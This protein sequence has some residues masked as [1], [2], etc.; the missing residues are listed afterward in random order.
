LGSFGLLAFAIIIWQFSP[1]LPPQLELTIALIL[2]FGVG[3]LAWWVSK[4]IGWQTEKPES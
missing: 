1:T 3:V 2:W 4:K